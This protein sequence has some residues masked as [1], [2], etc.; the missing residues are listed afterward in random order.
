VKTNKRIM[1]LAENTLE[2]HRGSDHQEFRAVV[3]ANGY[4]MARGGWVTLGD[5]TVC[6][7][8]N[9]FSYMVAMTK[10]I[11]LREVPAAEV[12]ADREF[13]MAKDITVHEAEDALE[14]GE[15]DYAD[16]SRFPTRGL[17]PEV[18]AIRDRKIAELTATAPAD[19]EVA[20]FYATRVPTVRL[21]QLTTGFVHFTEERA[22]FT[23]GQCVSGAALDCTGTGFL[24]ILPESL[25]PGQERAEMIQCIPCHEASAAAYVRKLHHYAG[26]QE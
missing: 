5:E 3:E 13:V 22:D 12:A 24:R 18:D 15:V 23:E 4:K 21:G 8:W 6:R 19:L 14:A 2:G 11:I 25:L 10:E 9:A 7:G 1:A 16:D 17:I 20:Y 26:G